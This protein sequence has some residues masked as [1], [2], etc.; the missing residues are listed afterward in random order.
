MKITALRIDD[1]KRIAHVAIIP[2]ERS[3]ILIAGANAQGKSSIL[4][5]L[6]A[7]L[8]GTRTAPQEPIRRGAK[9]ATI[10]IETDDGLQIRRTFGPTGATLEVSDAHGQVRRPQERLDALIGTRFLDPLAFLQRAA[11]EQR[12]ALLAVIPEAA[13]IAEIDASRAKA[14]AARTDVKRDLGKL[15]ARIE[16]R[17]PTP[18]ARAAP[19]NI[20]ELRE[21]GVVLAGKLA[22]ERN[23]AEA[24]ERG[25]REAN[26]M[27]REIDD[28]EKRIA[29]LQDERAAAI[30][31]QIAAAGRANNARI[32]LAAL[33]DLDQVRA[34][35][36]ANDRALAD[37]MGAESRRLAYVATTKAHREQDAER[38]NLAAQVADLDG[39]LALA[40]A[41]KAAI[42]SSTALPVDGLGFDD[43][44]ITFDG[45]PFA[46]ASG[47]QRI[48]VALG[49]AAASARDLREIWIKD[50]ALLDEDSLAAIEAFAIAR[51]MRVWIERVGEADTDAIVIRDGMVRP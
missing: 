16:A 17:G 51:D 21:R 35:V 33:G 19:A 47:A 6:D 36:A 20:G 12:A 38:V 3:I 18:V 37:V 40:D 26:A 7:A 1:F 30:A 42:L 29:K 10:A 41:T 48:R 28:L 31:R 15:E 11:A 23:C 39:D 43:T 13:Q 8:R 27:H 4:D 14:F 45:L 22:S 44:G 9:R 34:E 50:G 46:Q 2:G 5:A 49:L 24:I 32:Q 25:E